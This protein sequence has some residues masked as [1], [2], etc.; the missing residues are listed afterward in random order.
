[1]TRL[2]LDSICALN[3]VKI[4]LMSEI[5]YLE[6]FHKLF[7]QREIPHFL[8]EAPLLPT[9]SEGSSAKFANHYESYGSSRFAEINVLKWNLLREML[10]EVDTGERII[11]SDFDIIWYDTPTKEIAAL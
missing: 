11:F 5:E 7:Q 2:C 8:Y 1:M 4:F 6:E 10:N 3:D 9:E